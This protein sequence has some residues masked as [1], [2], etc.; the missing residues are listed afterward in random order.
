MRI[1]LTEVAGQTLRVGIR[2]GDKAR[3]PLLLFNGIGGNIE[4]V[5]PFLQRLAGPE[6]IVFDVPGVGGSPAPKLP[7]RPST[8]V[9]LAA[10]DCSTSSDT[11]RST[12]SASPGAARSPSNSR[13]NRVRAVAG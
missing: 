9:R 10:R 4:L 13:F 7:Y 6:A 11:Q 1:S 12:C 5:E 8:M 2:P 3:T